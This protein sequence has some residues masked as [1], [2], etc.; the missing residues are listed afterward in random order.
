MSGDAEGPP[1][2]R[3]LHNDDWGF[4]SNCFVCEPTNDDGLQIPFYADDDAQQ[5][6]ARFTLDGTFS[7]A[8]TFVHGGV[9]LAILD[10][11]QSWATIALG[12]KFAVTTETTS[13]FER[14]VMV[15]ETYE[16]RAW[17]TDVGDK[18]I[19]TAAEVRNAEDEVCASTTATFVVLS[20][21]VARRAIGEAVAGDTKDYLRPS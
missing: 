3:R 10:E 7:G 8:P 2:G 14:P 1:T 13:R 9:T 12:G 15:G 4:D 21:A 16:A 6:T 20:E 17:L 18:R 11:A 19:L 5:V